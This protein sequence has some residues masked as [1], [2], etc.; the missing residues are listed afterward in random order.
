[1][2][3]ILTCSIC[4][5]KIENKDVFE[6]EDEYLCEECYYEDSFRCEYCGDRFLVENRFGDDDIGLCEHCF[7]EHYYTCT[8]CDRLL[9][10][11]DVY[12]D[13]DEPYCES[14]YEDDNDNDEY[15]I[16][17]YSY[18]PTPR[19]CKCHHEKR[20]RYYG[21]ELEIDKGGCEEDYAEQLYDIANRYDDVLY[22]KSDGSLNDGMELVSHPCSLEY[23]RNKFPWEDV[24]HKAIH[25]GYRSHNTTSCGLH[26]HIGSEQLGTS[27]EYQE[28]VISRILFFFESHWNELF[29]FSR[30][31][32]YTVERWAARQGYSDRPKDILEKAKKSSKGRYSCVN[33]TNYSTVEIRMFRG[34]LKYNTFIATL[35]LVDS[36]CENAV[37][38]SDEE[39]HK[40]SWN[41]FVMSLDPD[42]EELVQYLKERRLYVNE[43]IM[44]EEEV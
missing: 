18:K 34:T 8:R 42:Y 5:C 4:G 30:R 43:P 24:M 17:S 41:D 3:E 38:L 33:V 7:N 13:G 2:S 9:Y 27:I 37:R 22:I 31:S 32:E 19:F 44:I 16:H 20:I 23:H 28:E 25:L 10:S 1:M 35:E 26:V 21:V 11:D 6:V 12:W 39:M 14:C 36:I 40:Q 15:Y 29:K